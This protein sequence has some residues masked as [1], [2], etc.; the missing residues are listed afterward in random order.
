MNAAEKHRRMTDDASPRPD[1]CKLAM[2]PV[3]EANAPGVAGRAVTGPSEPKPQGR[4]APVQCAPG[5]EAFMVQWRATAPATMGPGVE[6][7][8][9]SR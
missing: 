5:L 2:S 1:E 6:E 8:W 7:Q 9:S 3:A 4:R